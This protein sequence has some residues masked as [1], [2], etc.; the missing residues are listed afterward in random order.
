MKKISELIIFIFI[1]H[2]SIS[3]CQS[4]VG[5]SKKKLQIGIKKRIEN[6][7]KKSVKG[8]LLHMHYSVS[9]VLLIINFSVSLNT[10]IL[11]ISRENLKMALSLIAVMIENNP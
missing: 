10:I 11:F 6:C 1:L 8:D 3:T 4:N 5:D 9:L 2:I 7:I